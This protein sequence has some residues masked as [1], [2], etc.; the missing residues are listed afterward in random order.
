MD[1]RA[2]KGLASPMLHTVQNT[3]RQSALATRAELAADPVRRFLGWLPKRT[4]QPGDGLI[5]RPCSSIHMFGMHF[6][7]DALY[8]DAH[9]Q[10]LHAVE[11]L[12]PWRIG[13]MDPRAAMVIELPAGVVRAT[14]TQIGDH[15]STHPVPDPTEVELLRLNCLTFRQ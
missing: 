4:I 5:L 1:I 6:A 9:G 2:A 7:I 15:I 3:T 11:H 12:R 14:G 8:L 10:V 13:P